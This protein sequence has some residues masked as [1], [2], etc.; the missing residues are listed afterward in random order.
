MAALNDASFQKQHWYLIACGFDL[1]EWF[2]SKKERVC[3][4]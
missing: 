3:R 2:E 4:A 1:D